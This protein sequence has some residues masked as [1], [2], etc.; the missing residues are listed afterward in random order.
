VIEH[1]PAGKNGTLAIAVKLDGQT[2]HA[3]KLDI[4]RASARE[5]LTKAITEAC[6][7]LA[8]G[9]VKAELLRI[10][11]D[12]SKPDRV[13]G[14][15]VDVSRIVRPELF[16]RAD[17]SGISIPVVAMTETG[18]VGRWAVYLRWQDGLRERRDLAPCIDLPDGGRLW[19]N[20]RP[21]PPGLTQAAGWSAESRQSWLD[22]EPCPEP[23]EVFKSLCAV[24]AYY[25]DFSA[26]T[27]A[28]TTALLSL[29]AMLSYCYPAWAAVPY[30]SVGG[31]LASGKSRVFEVLA[32]LVFRPMPSANCTA[33]TLF[34]SLHESGGVLLLDEAE[35]LRDGTPDAG[36]IRS[37][38]LSGYKAGSPARRLEPC[39]DGRFKTLSFDV[40][41]PKAIAGIASLPEALASR[42]IRVTM[43]R[44]APDSPKPRRQIDE[45]PDRWQ[46]LRDD[47]HVMALEHGPTWF[48]LASHRDVCPSMD[49]RSFELW[50]PVL[51]IAGWLEERGAAGLLEMMQAYAQETIDL[52][53][54]DQVPDVDE[55]LLRLLADSVMGGFNDGLTPAE[56]LR[57]ANEREPSIFAKWSTRGIASTLKRYGIQ[58]R[59]SHGTRTYRDVSPF[60]LAEIERRYG[61]DLG[62]PEGTRQMGKQR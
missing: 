8:E 17:V 49:G 40:Y 41:G 54:D 51:A 1:R 20:P 29:W 30:L 23:V 24:T 45:D 11:A 7:A 48:Q 50:Q 56:L 33:P 3:D 42:C 26:D 13:A 25:L 52:N 62:L 9:D 16:H 5:R 31:T 27:A 18:P 47:L 38:L 2:V 55:L 58:A 22:G 39:G 35:R 57:R 10:A 61:L 28:Q 34:R 6:P 4:H 14:D 46:Q 12:V 59:Q 21:A 43:F 60:H 37:I 32:R 53:R 19:L 15:E 36:D 44:A